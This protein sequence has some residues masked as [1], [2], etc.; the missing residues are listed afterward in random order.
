MGEPA[1][2]R[3]AASGDRPVD[4]SIVIPCH[5]DGD[6]LLEAV[7]SAE[8]S[9]PERAELVIVDDGSRE[10][11]TLAVLAD[12]RRLGY[13]VIAQE[14][15][16]LAAARNRGIR[17]A[18]GRYLLP[19]DADNRLCPGFPAAAAA[20][21]DA[22][23]E[24]GVVYGDREEF[25]LRSGR[26]P[27]QEFDLDGL[28]RSNFIDACA[29]FRRAVWEEGGGYDGAMPAQGW[30]DWD[31][32]IGAAERGWRFH[33]LPGV[34]FEYRVRPGSMASR[35]TRA[36][37]GEPLRL[38]MID[39]H[40]DLY[41]RRLPT[42]LTAQHQVEDVRAELAAAVAERDRERAERDGLAAERDQLTVERDGL[43]AERERLATECAA[44]A[45][46][47][48]SAGAERGRLEGERDRLYAELA[49]YRRQVSFMEGTR[50]WRLRELALRLLRRL[51]R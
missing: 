35:L 6:F 23:P 30:E 29:V 13:R 36:E 44:R 41:R 26:V 19:L 15:A 25:G 9:A 4:L 47:L 42:L 10:A 43:E 46:E 50:A 18:R 14:N 21:L 39:K 1:G 8:R 17:E 5:D 3:L 11:R 31:L 22:A 34:T 51:K 7:E 24:V 40:Y 2:R 27:V 49:A 20:V 16:G 45:A 37:V 33:R 28:L 32:W 48:L 38:Y 12:L